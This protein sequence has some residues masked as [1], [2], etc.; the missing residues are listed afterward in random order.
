MNA[1]AAIAITT[2]RLDRSPH[3][4]FGAND[5]PARGLCPGYPGSALGRLC[6]IS[7]ARCA[8]LGPLYGSQL[9]ETTIQNSRTEPYSGPALQ[10]ENR[11]E[12]CGHVLHACRRLRVVQRHGFE[13]SDCREILR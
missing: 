6:S 11:R 13:A 12:T 2:V 5:E 4:M 1:T 3:M 10:P 9:D 7:L 8:R